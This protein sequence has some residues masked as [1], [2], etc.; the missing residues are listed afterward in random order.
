LL[1]NPAEKNAV[2]DN[3]I[4][5]PRKALE[6]LKNLYQIGEKIGYHHPKYTELTLRLADE[7]P[8]MAE[9]RHWVRHLIALPLLSVHYWH[10][11]SQ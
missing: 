5:N 6:M 1:H 7:S 3:F 2:D 8:V 4:G 10:S 11:Q 9:L